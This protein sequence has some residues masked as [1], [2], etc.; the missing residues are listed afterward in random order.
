VDN[1]ESPKKLEIRT[2]KCGVGIVRWAEY[3][4]DQVDNPVDGG[5]SNGN[6]P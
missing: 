4:K 3:D 5:N 6:R 2:T 1:K